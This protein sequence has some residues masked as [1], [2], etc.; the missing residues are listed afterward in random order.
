MAKG[1]GSTTTVQQQLAPEQQDILSLIMP[2]LSQYANPATQPAPYPGPTLAGLTPAQLAGQQSVLNAAQ[3]PVAAST[4]SAL[5]GLDFMT[6]GSVLDPNRNPGLAG[7]VQAATQP[8]TT[9]YQT[10]VLPSIRGEAQDS[11]MY[12]TTRH[13]VAEGLASDAYLRNVANA[14]ANV[15]NPAY[16]SGLEAMT[17]SL[18]FAPSV[19][20]SGYGP[21]E[22]MSAVGGQQQ[23][24][25]QAE[26]NAAINQYIQENYLPLMLA[27]EIAGMAFGLPIGGTVTQSSGGGTSP[28]MSG[29]GGA[30][31]GAGLGSMI[32]PGI[33][34]GIGALL[35]GLLGAFG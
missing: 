9:A 26:I 31:S 4:G 18:A 5:S 30:A 29:L 7:A 35:G 21:G 3:G 25:Q 11:G 14:T 33:G 10:S 2:T 12:G 19:L 28:L 32:F 24:Q 17:R 23:A 20:Q 15:V 22:A 13:G 6:S 16:Q 1:G 27:R 34:T 8:I